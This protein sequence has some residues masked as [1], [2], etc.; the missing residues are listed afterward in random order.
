MLVVPRPAAAGPAA[1][2]APPRAAVEYTDM[3]PAPASYIA[4]RRM[5][6]H[7][8]HAGAAEKKL[9]VLCFC[10]TACA[11]SDRIAAKYREFALRFSDDAICVKIDVVHFEDLKERCKV[12][13]TPTFVFIRDGAPVDQLAGSND[14]TLFV[15]FLKHT[16]KEAPPPKDPWGSTLGASG[17]RAESAGGTGEQRGAQ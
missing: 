15:K 17:R 2:V 8:L 6:E 5:Y 7:V 4:T 10:S 16:K 1:P 14:V 3:L 13:S 11:G 12:T 9:V